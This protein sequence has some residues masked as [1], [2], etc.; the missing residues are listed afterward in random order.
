MITVTRTAAGRMLLG[1]GA[2]GVVASLLAVAVGLRTLGEFEAALDRS[3]VM[4]AEALET[5]DATVAVAERSLATLEG[6]LETTG[7][8]ARDVVTS[9]EDAERLL[10]ATADLSEDRLAASLDAVDEALPTLVEVAGVI[11]RT[12]SALSLVPLGPDYDPDEPFDESLRSIQRELAGMPDDVRQQAALIRGTAAS[13]EDVRDGAAAVADDLDEL[14]AGLAD[15][16]ELLGGYSRTAT[17]ARRVVA[18]SQDA[19]DGQLRLVRVLLVVLGLTFAAGQV[20]PLG[21]GWLLLRPE[22]AEA[23]WRDRAVSSRA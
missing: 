16:A 15:A 14:R 1:V 23:F 8:T 22:A 4:T 6:G 20:V 9:F 21:A 5:L 19:L 11:D 10:E 13:L 18:D 2:A 7:T 17:R 12:L 3:M